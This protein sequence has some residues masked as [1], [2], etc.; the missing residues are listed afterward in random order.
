[1]NCRNCGAVYG[2]GANFCAIC[3]TRVCYVAAPCAQPVTGLMRL[4]EGRM[5]AGVC[6]GLSWYYGWDLALVRIVAVLLAVLAFP[7]GIIAYLAAWLI[8]PEAPLCVVM[9][10]MQQPVQGHPQT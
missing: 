2:E 7:V 10:P 5:I 8:I 1:M 6:A 9:P 3:G 4:H